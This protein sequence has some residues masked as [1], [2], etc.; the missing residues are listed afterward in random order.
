M[1]LKEYKKEVLNFSD[2]RLANEYFHLHDELSYDFVSVDKWDNES[3]ERYWKQDRPVFKEQLKIVE[4][5][6][7][8]RHINL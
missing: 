3:C 8:Y 4:N 7:S 6:L 1:D 2:D 5:E